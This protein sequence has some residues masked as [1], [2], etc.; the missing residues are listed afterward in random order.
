MVLFG[1]ESLNRATRE[2]LEHYHRE[3][4]HQGLDG[5]IIDAETEVGRVVGKIKSK[6]RLSGM[7]RYYYREAA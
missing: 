7:R 3:R 1:Q 5:K 4:N 6:K 2:Y